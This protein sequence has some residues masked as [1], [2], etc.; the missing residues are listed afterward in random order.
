M[1][2]HLCCDITSAHQEVPESL[3]DSST[4]L[5]PTPQQST[6]SSQE[7]TTS[8]TSS[9]NSLSKDSASMFLFDV[10]FVKITD[11]FARRL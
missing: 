6:E 8:Q 2:S 5:Q 4:V 1:E 10:F 11:L 9:P 3:Q 7:Q